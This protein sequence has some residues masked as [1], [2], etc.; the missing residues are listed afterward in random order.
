MRRDA[1]KFVMV[2][3]ILLIGIHG[4][5][6]Q[7]RPAAHRSPRRSQ[8]RLAGRRRGDPQHGARCEPAEAGGLLRSNG[9]GRL[10]EAA[11]ATAGHA[12]EPPR[13][14][15]ER[16]ALRHRRRHRAQA[17]PT[18]ISRSAASTCSSATITA[19]T[20]TT[21]RTRRKPRLL[22]SVVCPGGQ[23]DVSVHGN[24]LF[25]SVEQT[26]G[27]LDCGTAGRPDAGQHRA[28]PRRPH[29]RHQ[30]S[31][32]ARSRWRR[33]RPAADRTRTR[34]SPTPTDKDNIYIYG[35]GTGQV[36]S[37]EELDGCSGADPKRIRTRRSSAS[38]SFKVPLA[39]AAEGQDRQSSAHLRGPGDRQRSPACGRAAITAT[40]RRRRASPVSVTTSRCF[41]RWVSPPARARATAS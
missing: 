14:A 13:T 15:A 32:E 27:R 18:P 17:S 19:S 11:R 28:L 23:G 41:R 5:A 25:M 33:C 39:R 10:G 36:R 40:G 26:R 3:A 35:S 1:F 16:R 24:L 31:E 21:S 22:A 29:L 34:W 2:A 9:A 6:Q 8:G 20:R 4:L 7:Q 37:G 12:A 38:T 30:R